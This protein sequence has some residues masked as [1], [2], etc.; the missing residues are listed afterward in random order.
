[1]IPLA[2]VT[3][4]SQNTSKKLGRNISQQ[5]RQ[6]LTETVRREIVSATENYAMITG[7]SKSSVEFA[8]Q[9][10]KREAEAA[11][12]LPL[13]EPSTLYFAH[14]FDSPDTAPGDLA[15]S[16][17]HMKKMA[18][19]SLVPKRV[20]HG[21]PNFLLAPGVAEAEMAADLRRLSRLA[22]VLKGINA[23]FGG[24]LL[25]IYA[26]LETGLHIS[27]PGHGGYPASYDPRRR[28]WYVRA[29]RA[30]G[31]TWGSPIVDSTTGQ[32]TFTAS[33]PFSGPAGGIAGV[34]AID[35]LIPKVLLKRQISD[36]WSGSMKSFLVGRGNVSGADE[37]EIWVLSQ[38]RRETMMDKGRGPADED[39]RFYSSQND[40]LRLV[41]NVEGKKS[42]S[43]EM[44]YRGV[45]SLWA[46]AEVFPGL[47]FV[48]VAP[49]SMVTGLSESV[50]E[51]FSEYTR[52]QSL[53]TLVTILAVIV[54]VALAALYFS[55]SNTKNVMGIVDGFKALKRG[56]FS[57][58]LRLK[59][60]DE[61]DRVVTAFNE[62]VPR[63]EEHL[64][65][66]RA[67]GLAKDVQQSLLPKHDPKLDGFDIA[68]S[69]LYCEETGG[70]YFD[71]IP[72][73]SNRLAVV[74]G[75]VSGHGVSSAL[76]MATARALIML[77]ASMP[78]PAASII[79][80]VNRHLCQDT[81]DTGNFMTFFYCELTAR[82]TPLTWIRA[83]HD[84]ALLYDP[85]TDA[86]D[87]LR[88]R[89]PAFGLD[90]TF[91]YAESS[92]TLKYGQ[93]V[94]IGTDGIWEMRSEA[95]E[96][97]GKNRLKE[98]IRAHR[99]EAAAVIVAAIEADLQDFQNRLPPDD[100]VT[101][102]V[103]KCLC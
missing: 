31:L 15:P 40:F 92:R 103:I 71:Y 55:R 76:L 85:E 42:G 74:V 77:R 88:G 94:L 25:W 4:I 69:S 28:P 12:T 46:F 37:N 59:F 7:R 56:D 80:D 33:V 21:H 51:R 10:L 79:N 86:F 48:I 44:P 68:G 60:N 98:I 5:T 53:I 22:P 36:Q 82:K 45:D 2:V 50:G 49:R 100:D 27:Y 11:L 54:T 19:G 72:M 6:A 101:M 43:L 32:L 24:R 65:M 81:G 20:S 93:I 18:D 84:P 52:G 91:R 57:V 16:A 61:R 96:M 67:L 38:D 30:G 73:P 9:V 102:V 75:D 47:H 35:V 39:L 8:L 26:S 62:I 17:V 97:Y 99:S 70:D 3:V 90:D 89:G 34:A 87:E 23:E 1:M 78:G 63:L 13:P 58:R 64:R 83:G 66:R 14:A 29:R 41:R 95:G